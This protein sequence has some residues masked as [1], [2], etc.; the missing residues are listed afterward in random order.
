[1]ITNYTGTSV[2]GSASLE[3]SVANVQIIPQGKVARNFS[4]FNNGDA[5]V[6]INGK[7]L[8]IRDLQGVFFP[9]VYSFKFI[10][11]NITYNW[12]GIDA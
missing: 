10:T 6:E 2:L 1:M 11:P 12:V 9:T 7:L 5:T 4:L 8:F 3:T